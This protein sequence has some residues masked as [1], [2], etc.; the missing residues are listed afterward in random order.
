MAKTSFIRPS[1]R[2]RWA[3]PPGQVTDERRSDNYWLV[4]F[5]TEYKITRNIAV[6]GFVK[7]AFDKEYITNNRSGDILDV[8]APRTLGLALRYDL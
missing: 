2:C 7:N 6:S 3:Q 8:G 1:T 5:N 4:N